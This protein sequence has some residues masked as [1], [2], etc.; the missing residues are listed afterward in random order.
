VTPPW[1]PR[2]CHRSYSSPSRRISRWTPQIE[3]LSLEERGGTM[4]LPEPPARWARPA[5]WA[6]VVQSSRWTNQL[7]RHMHSCPS[8]P[9]WAHGPAPPAAPPTR[10]PTRL[11]TARQR[12]NFLLLFYCP[13]RQTARASRPSGSWWHHGPSSAQ[14]GRDSLDLH[15]EP[16]LVAVL[17][18][19]RGDG[20]GS[21]QM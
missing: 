20:S 6:R 7:H 17:Y 11:R 4:E 2:F 10:S 16:V 14:Q 9:I 19:T 15:K 8:D 3:P 5:T 18:A 12:T 1:V 13:P 21:D